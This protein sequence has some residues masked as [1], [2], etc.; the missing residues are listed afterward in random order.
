MTI[1]SAFG[2]RGRDESS[3]RFQLAEE[4]AA[5]AAFSQPGRPQ[6]RPEQ[7]IDIIT[8]IQVNFWRA[9]IEERPPRFSSYAAIPA[10]TL[11]YESQMGP[12]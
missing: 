4:V 3:I 8:T 2:Y 7:N 1:H 5:A 9:I 12:H 11:N 6:L 10:A